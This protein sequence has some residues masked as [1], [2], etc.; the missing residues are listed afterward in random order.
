MSTVYASPIWLGRPHC[1]VTVTTGAEAV[2]TAALGSLTLTATADANGLCAMKL[3]RRGRWSFTAVLGGKKGF[4]TLAVP[5]QRSL[6][7]P[8]Y[9]TTLA[10]NSWAEIAAAAA[11][12]IAA[13]LWSPGD[14]KE[15]TISGTAGL[16]T[17][18]D[19]TIG[20]IILG[21]DHNAALEGSGRIHFQLARLGATP[22]ALVDKR[23]GSFSDLAGAFTMNTTATSEGGWQGC[24]MRQEILG[25]DSADVLAPKEGTLLALMPEELRAVM[26][27]CTKYTDNTGNSMEAAA[28][29][30]TQ[31]WLFLLSEWEYYGARTMANEGEQ[32]FQQQYAYYA[33][34]GSP[35]K[36]RHNRTTAT[37]R[38]WCRSPAAGWAGF[39]HV[40]KDG[41]AYYEAPN[42]DL[43]IAPAFVLG[44]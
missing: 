6:S 19:L 18:T 1:P 15:L 25:S 22:V 34:G 7:L 27:P 20:A 14:V 44:A 9:S 21:F 41:T 26:K 2:V 35:A 31:E 38:D 29:T 40:N 10:E 17:V 4:G 39:C 8:L 33:A 16:L 11:A 5:G 3:P 24:H 43:G 36:M 30:A 13:R 42:A 37:A 32:S 12:G 23:H 28:V